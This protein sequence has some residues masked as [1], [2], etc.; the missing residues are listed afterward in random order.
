MYKKQN[1][2]IGLI[3]FILTNLVGPKNLFSQKSSAPTVV[4][5]SVYVFEAKTNGEETEFPLLPGEITVTTLEKV[6]ETTQGYTEKLRSIYSF[7]HFSLLTTMAGAF[8]VGLEKGDGGMATSQIYEKNHTFFLYTYCKS[9]PKSGLLPIR[10]EAQL[11]TSKNR[12]KPPEKRIIH[13]FQTLCMVKNNHPLVIGRPLEFHKGHKKKAIFVVFTPFFQELSRASQY[14]TVIEY[15]RKVRQL[16]PGS[17][18][19]RAG[20]LFMGINHYFKTKLHRKKLMALKDILSPPPSPTS[21]EYVEVQ[22]ITFV[23]Y[24]QAP[25][26][27]GGFAA[28]QKNLTYPEAARKAGIEG[29]VLL[30]AQIDE[31]GNVART[32]VIRS[33][34]VTGCDKAAV[35]AINSVKWIPAKQK[36]KP[37]KVWIMV[38]VDFKLK[39]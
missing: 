17:G 31:N 5:Y 27:I 13:L 6:I 15:Y 2:L 18:D 22:G 11:D 32:K 39:H 38:P 35:A 9:G 33:L 28:I 34:G 8:S 4:F 16:T 14:E 36:G 1:L 25:A 12:Q 19:L 29:R 23:P 24:N 7:K 10:I 3:I 26:P 20:E 30:Y 37:V 21:S